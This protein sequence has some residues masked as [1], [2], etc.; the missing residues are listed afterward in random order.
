[1][2]RGV[3]L[4]AAKDLLRDFKRKYPP[5]DFLVKAYDLMQSM[6]SCMSPDE[7]EELTEYMKRLVEE[8]ESAT[9]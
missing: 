7:L 1:M 3:L 2:R 4:D 9:T 5:E 8:N 6:K